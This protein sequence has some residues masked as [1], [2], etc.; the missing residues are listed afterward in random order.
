MTGSFP[1]QLEAKQ[2]PS[3][4]YSPKILK[5]ENRE[6]RMWLRSA[7]L[8]LG[9]QCRVLLVGF[10]CLAPLPYWKAYSAFRDIDGS[11]G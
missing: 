7:L 4:T 11:M 1:Q 6:S 2:N 9:K 10:V 8:T 3:L 5:F